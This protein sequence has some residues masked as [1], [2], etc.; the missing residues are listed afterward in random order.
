[1]QDKNQPDKLKFFRESEAPHPSPSRFPCPRSGFHAF[2]CRKQLSEI[3]LFVE[4]SGMSSVISRMQGAR[5]ATGHAPL[6][7]GGG[8][9][10]NGMS[11]HCKRQVAGA[12]TGGVLR[13]AVATTSTSLRQQA[14]QTFCG[15]IMCK[16]ASTAHRSTPP[17]ALF[18]RHPPL[19]EGR[20]LAHAP[21]SDI[22]P[23]AYHHHSHPL[24]SAK[25]RKLPELSDFFVLRLFC[26]PFC[27]FVSRKRPEIFSNHWKTAEKFF[28]SLEKM[29]KIFQPLEK[30]FPIIGKL[31][32]GPRASG[33]CKTRW[34]RG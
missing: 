16:Q 3:G 13:A 27:P 1:M 23:Q 34:V 19:G 15:S 29:A 22:D 11:M 7:E 6:R 10:M 33:L 9:A 4:F 32:V 8:A 25:N 28:Q 5:R 31:A 17:A 14:D 18:G 24:K 21:F 12:A 26:W 2:Q 20:M 30:N